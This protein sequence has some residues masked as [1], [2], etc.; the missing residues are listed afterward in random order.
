MQ[1]LAMFKMMAQLE[2]VSHL[3]TMIGVLILK[4]LIEPSQV[5]SVDEAGYDRWDNIAL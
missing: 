5:M 2:K 4:S 3:F 1:I